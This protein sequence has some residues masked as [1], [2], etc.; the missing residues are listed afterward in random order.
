MLPVSA[1][2]PALPGPPDSSMPA[3]L[4]TEPSSE[5]IPLYNRIIC[6][7]GHLCMH[8]RALTF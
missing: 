2:P 1:A 5:S 7:P 4:V 8:V 6:G 3:D